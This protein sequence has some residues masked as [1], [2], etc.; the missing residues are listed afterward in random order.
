M[1]KN[2]LR[3]RAKE[4]GKSVIL[5]CKNTNISYKER[6]LAEQL[7]RSATSIGANIYE[8]KYAQS[9]SDFISK[10]EIS[11]KEAYET[12]YWL[13][14]LGETGIIPEDESKKLHYECGAIRRMLISSINTVKAKQI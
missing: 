14:L 9:N 8:A 11:L 5:L 10:F 13:E 3:K 7:L 2:D 1:D 12:E 4:F 6:T